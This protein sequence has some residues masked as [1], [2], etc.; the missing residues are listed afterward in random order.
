MH[1]TPIPD[2]PVDVKLAL[3]V[4]SDPRHVQKQNKI[5]VMHGIVLKLK[6]KP[7]F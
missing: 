5:N 6:K 7:P 1:L 4:P 2:D 3:V